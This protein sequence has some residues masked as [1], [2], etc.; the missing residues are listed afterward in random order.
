MATALSGK[1]APGIP[2]Q[3][4]HRPEAISEGRDHASKGFS[5]IMA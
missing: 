4:N 1:Q 2:G 3:F 5:A